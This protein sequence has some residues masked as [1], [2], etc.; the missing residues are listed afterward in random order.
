MAKGMAS[1]GLLAV[2]GLMVLTI[3]VYAWRDGG[4]EPLREMAQPVPVPEISR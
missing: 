1:K 3:L 4:R 2:I